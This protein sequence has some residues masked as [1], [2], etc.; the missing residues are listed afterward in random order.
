MKTSPTSLRSTFSF[1]LLLCV[2]VLG[3]PI[4]LSAQTADS[5]AKEPQFL[6]GLSGGIHQVRHT[7][8]IRAID[9]VESPFFG[10]SNNLGWFVGINGE[11]QLHE[12]W[13]VN[14]QL[15]YNN[16]SGKSAVRMVNPSSYLYY[17]VIVPIDTSI[18]LPPT[19]T[20]LLHNLYVAYSTISLGLAGTWRTFVQDST[21]GIGITAGPVLHY[22]ATMNHRQT[23]ELEQPSNTRIHDTMNLPTESDGTTFILADSDI[24][25]AN[26]FRLGLHVGVFAEFGTTWSGVLISPG[27]FYDY[28]L[29]RV[30]SSEDW[31]GSLETNNSW[32]VHTL[33]GR[34]DVKFGL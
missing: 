5:T 20:I 11:L 10:P 6:V 14:V 32:F 23:M 1:V 12:H 33:S 29:Q 21:I 34:L 16:L 30:H 17:G 24:P 22:I 15:L 9:A 18:H 19:D 2:I 26:D 27:I 13:S 25:G 4:H 8:G 7:L 28:S 3:V 31:F